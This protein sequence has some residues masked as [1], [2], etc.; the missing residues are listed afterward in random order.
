MPCSFAPGDIVYLK[1]VPYTG[2]PKYHL[3]LSVTDDMFFVIN[4]NINTTVAVNSLFL[5][6]QVKLMKNPDNVY[7]PKDESYIACHQLAPDL[8]SA[9]VDAQIKAG[10]GEIKGRL[11]G[12]TIEQ[13]IN[14]VMN[15][16]AH[17]LSPLERRVITQNLKTAL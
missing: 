10:N 17:T 6:C 15:H 7:M 14:T 1:T 13:V 9:E 11:D 8:I 16:C 4:S 2:H 3:V 5:N 12:T